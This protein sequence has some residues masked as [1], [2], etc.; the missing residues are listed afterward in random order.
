MEGTLVCLL[1]EKGEGDNR[2][3][4]SVL[5]LA[6]FVL[7]HVL[8]STLFLSFKDLL[9]S[10]LILLLKYTSYSDSEL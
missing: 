7:F 1:E 6:V 4:A 2:F 8:V 10:L 5:V 9:L 3:A